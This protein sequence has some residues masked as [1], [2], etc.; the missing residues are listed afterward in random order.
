MKKIAAFIVLSA[1][2]A[3]LQAQTKVT[4]TLD[5]AAYAV[6]MD[7]AQMVRSFD[8]TLN[9]ELV[10]RGLIDQFNGTSKLNSVAAEQ[11]IQGFL[12]ARQQQQQLSERAKRDALADESAK[13][14]ASIE[15]QQGISK[16]KSGLLYKIEK[17]GGERLPQEGDMVTVHY[18]LKLPDGTVM[19][20]SYDRGE[21]LTYPNI[22]GQMI[23]GFTEGLQLLGEGGKAT[24]YL[25]P[26]LAYKE[27]GSGAIRPNQAIIFEV[28]LLAI[29]PKK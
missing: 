29:T 14:L 11:A 21:P 19:D 26:C 28:A 4:T 5:S 18:T 13:F 24:L 6:G 25:P 23:E 20:S 15:A 27:Y 12:A 9:I 1:L 3:S 10:A 17:L 22:K 16:T 7:L 2:T 8:T